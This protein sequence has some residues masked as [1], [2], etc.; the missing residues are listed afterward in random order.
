[1]EMKAIV[2]RSR[3]GLYRLEHP[4]PARQDVLPAV[5]RPAHLAPQILAVDGQGRLVGD[6]KAEV[7]VGFGVEGAL[8]WRFC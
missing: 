3:G 4:T 6:Q 1:M 5:Q 8:Q 2:L 7:I